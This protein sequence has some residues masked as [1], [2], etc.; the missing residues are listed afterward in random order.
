MQ[1][2]NGIEMNGIEMS[3][4]EMERKEKGMEMKWG[5]TNFKISLF[6][7]QGAIKC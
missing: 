7:F 2:R 3:G 5:K 6:I 1:Q 4:K